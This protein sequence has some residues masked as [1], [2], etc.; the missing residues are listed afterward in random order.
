MSGLVSGLQNRVRR[1]ESARNLIK[2]PKLLIIKGFGAFLV[3]SV[4][5]YSYGGKSLTHPDSGKCLANAKGVH[6]ELESEERSRQT[7]GLTYRNRI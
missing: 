5:V 4:W 6:R 1:F 2:A 3:R 7:S